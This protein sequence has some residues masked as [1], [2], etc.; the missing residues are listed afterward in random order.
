[1]PTRETIENAVGGDAF[2]VPAQIGPIAASIAL[3]GV[4]VIAV[5]L[6][7]LGIALKAAL[8]SSDS[9]DVRYQ[10]FRDLV[11]IVGKVIDLA[12][13]LLMPFRGRK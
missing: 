12:G 5:L 8:G 13:D 2:G 10:V 7:Y 4:V 9:S 3:F 1:M 11:G 6:L